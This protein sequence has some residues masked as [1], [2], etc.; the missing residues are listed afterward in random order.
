MINF[1]DDFPRSDYGENNLL[2][3]KQ[4]IY[5]QTILLLFVQLYLTFPSK[6]SQYLRKERSEKDQGDSTISFSLTLDSHQ[7][8]FKFKYSN[9]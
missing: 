7:N 4:N 9:F 8:C 1:W 2:L 6:V 3:E 5:Y